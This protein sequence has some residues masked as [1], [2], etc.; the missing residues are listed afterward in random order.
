MGSSPFSF[1]VSAFRTL[2]TTEG[3]MTHN[4]RPVQPLNGRTVKFNVGGKWD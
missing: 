2:Y 3:Q 4:Y 1:Q